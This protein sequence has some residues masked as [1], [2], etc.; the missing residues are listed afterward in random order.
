M[1]QGGIYPVTLAV[2]DTNGC[3]SQVTRNIEIFDFFNVFIPNSFTPNNDGFNDLW[4]V[5]GTDIDP[6]RFELSV[7]NRW[8]KE[9]FRTED[10]DEGW[11][12]QAEFEDVDPSQWYYAQDGVYSY[13]VVLYSEST[14]EKRE[15]KGYITLN[16]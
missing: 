2:V 1:G 12:G 7:F 8:G 6:D 9:V 16:R 14:N 3:E 13:R 5:Y 11:A 4:K 10:L 15:I